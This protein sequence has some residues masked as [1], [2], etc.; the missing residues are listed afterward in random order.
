GGAAPVVADVAVHRV[1]R[2]VPDG[3]HLLLEHVRAAEGA[4]VAGGDLHLRAAGGGRL[5]GG[6][7]ARRAGGVVDLRGRRAHRRRHLAGH[8][9]G[10]AHPRAASA[11]RLICYSRGVHDDAPR[12]FTGRLEL[13][14]T[15]ASGWGAWR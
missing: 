9:R 2:D 6:G 7:D 3:G 10:A 11:A 8:A 14:A 1:H 12:L 13:I 4:V 15:T 5:D